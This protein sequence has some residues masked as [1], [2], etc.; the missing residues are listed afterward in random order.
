V[1]QVAGGSFR[2]DFRVPAQIFPIAIAA[3]AGGSQVVVMNALGNT[4]NLIDVAKVTATAPPSYTSETANTLPQYHADAIQ[5]FND[6][7]S[8]LA[9][10]IKDCF[11]DKFLVECHTC[12]PA[13]DRI[14]LGSIEIKAKRVHNI[15][16]FT[17]RHYAKSFRTWGYWLSTVPIL[18]LIK[19]AFAL[20]ACK[21]L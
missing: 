5:A 18:P 20:F 8:V 16:N 14:Y 7:A 4:L 2:N 1:F 9:Q 10:Y 11:C 15:C 3:S 21:V 6:L 19:R 12:D 17:R 13:K